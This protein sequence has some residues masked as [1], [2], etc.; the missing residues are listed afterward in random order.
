MIVFSGSW[1]VRPLFVQALAIAHAAAQELRPFGNGDLRLDPASHRCFRGD[2]E[3]ELSPRQFS[4]LEY[5][6]RHTGDACS[7]AQIIEHVWDQSF[8]GDPNIVEVYVR[9]LRNKLDRPFGREAIETV[10]SS[11]WRAVASIVARNSK[12]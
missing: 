4:M 6:M 2:V 9:H 10:D 11:R 3:V 1:R 7:K 12:R 5:L 8:D